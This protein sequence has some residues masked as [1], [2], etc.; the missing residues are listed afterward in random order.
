MH[1]ALYTDSNVFAGTERHILELAGALKEEGVVV[2]ICCPSDSPL[3]R[4]AAEMNIESIVIEKRGLL[5]IPAILTLRKLLASG[6]ID[7]VHAHN[8]R[9]ALAAA[10]AGRLARKGSVVATQ[11]F[12]DP[13]HAGRVGL[14]AGLY[15]GVHRWV[16]RETDHYIAISRA[17][18][19][20]MVAREGGLA[21][22]VTVVP[23]GI[24]APETA[25]LLPADE[26]RRDFGIPADGLLIVCAA[27]L[28]KEKDVPTL[29]AAMGPVAEQFPNA[30]CVIAGEG[31]EQ[32]ALEEQIRAA[33]L[34]G[35]ITLAGFRKDVLSL[36]NAAD[37]FVLPSRAEPFGLV[38]LEAMALGK[39]VV[40]TAAGGPLEIVKNGETGFLVPPG[41]SAALA[42]AIVGLLR[43]PEL[44]G[45]AG[46]KGLLRFQQEFTARA[47]ACATLAVYKRA[48]RAPTLQC[49]NMEEEKCESC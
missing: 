8:G 20:A 30:R 13:A 41:D 2:S 40:S 10:V 38:L 42:G 34:G 23:N 7:L 33:G 39:P 25:A 35:Q 18:E 15:R 31:E 26:V 49:P 16:Q 48:S 21:G 28:Q 43:D 36:I 17:V 3:R 4:A 27:R 32:A 14:L 29:V 46:E 44:R 1:V 12:I 24:S 45:L 47:M 11:H 6:R 19:D 22:K 5:D 9:T 37:V